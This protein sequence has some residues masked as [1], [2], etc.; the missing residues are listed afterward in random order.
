ME[1]KVLEIIGNKAILMVN[2]I[3]RNI[4]K[5]RIYIRNHGYIDLTLA[6]IEYTKGVF[7][8]EFFVEGDVINKEIVFWD[9]TIEEYLSQDTSKG[10]QIQN[11][12]V[13]ALQETK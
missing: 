4:N 3:N 13:L 8:F 9:M 10:L 5:W 1:A 6:N 7:D 12:K 11:K 2:E